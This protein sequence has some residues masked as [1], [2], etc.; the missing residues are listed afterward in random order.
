M[1]QG[2]LNHRVTTFPN[3]CISEL[4]PTKKMKETISEPRNTIYNLLL[5]GVYIDVMEKSG[6]WLLIVASLIPV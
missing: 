5:K 1:I 3:S 2:W 6:K 4:E